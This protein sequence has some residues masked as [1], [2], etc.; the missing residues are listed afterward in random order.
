LKTSWAASTEREE[1]TATASWQKDPTAPQALAAVTEKSLE[2]Q[3][4][5]LYLEL[6]AFEGGN[7]GEEDEQR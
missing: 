6:D 7:R 3:S 5:R 2:R 4:A 1:S